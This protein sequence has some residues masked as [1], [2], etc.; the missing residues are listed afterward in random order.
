MTTDALAVPCPACFVP[1]GAPCTTPTE[2]S[3][4]PVSWFHDSR[5]VA[6][7]ERDEE[8]PRQGRVCTCWRLRPDGSHGRGCD[9][10][11]EAPDAQG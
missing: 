5:L 3:R 1:V 8:Q 11:V 4:R 10:H 6:A 9:F 2:S 7:A